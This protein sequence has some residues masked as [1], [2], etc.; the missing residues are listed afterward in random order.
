MTIP[1]W[2][3]QLIEMVVRIFF[4]EWRRVKEDSDKIIQDD[5]PPPKSMTE[6]Y[7]EMVENHPGFDVPLPRPMAEH[8][9]ENEGM[10]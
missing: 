10:V 3:E 5:T 7:E 2:V 9:D 6:H 8:Y 1:P 4:K